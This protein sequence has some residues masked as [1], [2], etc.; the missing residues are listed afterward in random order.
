MLPNRNYAQRIVAELQLDNDQ[1]C[2]LLSL[3]GH[4]P[5]KEDEDNYS[6]VF[7]PT[8][9]VISDQLAD[10]SKKLR[11]IEI[12]KLEQQ[13]IQTQNTVEQLSS[14][15]NEERSS[16]NDEQLKTLFDKLNEDLSQMR[17]PTQSLTAPVILPPPEDMEVR[18]VSSTSLERLE[19]YRAEE[20]KW[21]AIMSLLLGT[22]LGV[23]INIVTG[24]KMT[25]EAWM[26]VI[27]FS[28]FA[29]FTGLTA[30][31]YNNELIV[32][33]QKFYKKA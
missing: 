23:F 5:L 15:I 27:I 19:E 26:F 28:G 7:R 2:E 1:A 29:V 16:K 8:G 17:I 13:L 30:S 24:A 33:V 14:K 12:Q 22:V 18:L 11:E 4:Y 25:T 10:G 31:R 3:A 32:F 21:Y 9:I 20:N 6:T